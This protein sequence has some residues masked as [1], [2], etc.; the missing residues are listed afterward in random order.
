MASG[1][2]TITLWVLD[3]NARAIAFYRKYGFDFDGE[4]KSEQRPGFTMRELRM[5]TQ[6]S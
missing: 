5:V 2:S 6:L 1:Y 3:S 4:E